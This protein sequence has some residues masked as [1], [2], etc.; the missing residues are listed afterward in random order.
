MLQ[1]AALLHVGNQRCRGLV[2]DFRLHGMRLE[3]VRVRIPIRNAIATP[4]GSLPLNS[5]TTRT[6]LSRYSRLGKNTVLRAYCPPQFGFRLVDPVSVESVDVG[7]IGE[8]HHIWDGS[9]HTPRELVAGDATCE[10]GITRVLAAR[11]FGIQSLQ[12]IQ[13]YR[14]SS[15]SRN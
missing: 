6:R 12:Q 9:L 15:S 7:F 8:V 10:V 2:H 1:E 14:R 3:D 5:W 11:C 13:P 4:E